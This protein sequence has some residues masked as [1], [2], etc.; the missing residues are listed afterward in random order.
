M[1]EEHSG[2]KDFQLRKEKKKIEKKYPK[3][4]D[5]EGPI[6]GISGLKNS[7]KSPPVHYVALG[8]HLLYKAYQRITLSGHPLSTFAKI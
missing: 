1:I 3:K 8:P 7:I 5:Q 6:L 2:L 4:C